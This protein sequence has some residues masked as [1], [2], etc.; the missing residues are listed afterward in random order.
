MNG[1]SV[2]FDPHPETV[3]EYHDL[4]MGIYLQGHDS[5]GKHQ[6]TFTRIEQSNRFNIDWSGK[7][8][9]TY[10]GDDEFKYDFTAYIRDVGCLY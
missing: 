7:I 4:A 8:A 3:N 5:C 6:L 1:L 2:S 9:K 10:F